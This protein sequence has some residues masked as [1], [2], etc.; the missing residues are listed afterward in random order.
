[1]QVTNA[2]RGKNVTVMASCSASGHFI[3]PMIIFK[4]QRQKPEFADGMPPD[5]LIS[6]S[7]S[8]YIYTDRCA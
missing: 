6:M 7:E 4:G 2:E 5:T 3:L 8:G 1:M